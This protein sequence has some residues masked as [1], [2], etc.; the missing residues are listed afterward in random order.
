MKNS[1]QDMRDHLFMALEALND[2]DQK[3]PGQIKQ[4]IARAGQIANVAGVLIE[5]AKVE[6]AFLRQVD[7]AQ[8]SGFMHLLTAPNST[9]KK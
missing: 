5:S 4:D 7:A 1:Y 3:E 6:L 2:T 9:S 8:P